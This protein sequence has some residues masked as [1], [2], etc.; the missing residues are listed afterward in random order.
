MKKCIFQA[1][2]CYSSVVKTTKDFLLQ[3]RNPIPPLDYIE[4]KLEEL[5]KVCGNDSSSWISYLDFLGQR[6]LEL[7]LDFDKQLEKMTKVYKRGLNFCKGDVFCIFKWFYD[8]LKIYGVSK[9]LNN[10]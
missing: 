6:K 7:D 3:I 2:S 4:Q 5:V 8:F 9:E 10:S 1:K